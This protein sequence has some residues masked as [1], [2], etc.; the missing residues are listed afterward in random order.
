MPIRL[1]TVLVILPLVGGSLSPAGAQQINRAVPGNSNSPNQLNAQGPASTGALG[2]PVTELQ[3]MEHLEA[4]G[5]SR[6]HNL[7]RHEHGWTAD[8]TK[9]GRH[10]QVRIDNRNRITAR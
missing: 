4:D 8:A 6:I 1:L 3:V 7:Q 9:D 2:G 5:Y 10:V